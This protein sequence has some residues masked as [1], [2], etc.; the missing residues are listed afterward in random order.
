MDCYVTVLDPK[1]ATLCM[2]TEGKA[3]FFTYYGGARINRSLR[4]S[5][6]VKI[7]D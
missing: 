6:A 4:H 7:D 1:V 3:N 5:N 2:R